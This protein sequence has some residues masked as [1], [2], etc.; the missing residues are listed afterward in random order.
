MSLLEVRDLAVH[1]H[2]RNGVVRAVEGVTFGLERGATLGVVGESGSGKSVTCLALMGLLACPPGR[3]ES[4]Q[5]LFEGEDLLRLSPREMRRIRGSRLG[6]VFQDPMEALNPYMRIGSQ[7]IE[8]L[9]LH[10]SLGKRDALDRAEQA[11]KEVGIADAGDRLRCYPHELSGGMRQRILIA[12]ALLT[13]PALLIADEPTTALDVTIQAQILDVIHRLQEAR[14]TAVLLVTHDLGIVAGFCEHVV[15]MYAGRIMEAA[16]VH[17]LFHHGL[18]PY[19]KALRRSLPTRERRSAELYTIPGRPPRNTERP[20][21]C[22]F[23]PRCEQR[24]PCCSEPVSLV[25]MTEQH[26]TACTRVVRGEIDP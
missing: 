21:G 18:H 2:T 1:F 4:G 16:P 22:P 12:M 3:I 17:E 11:L 26:A 5:I 19:T 6:M 9:R 15:V 14:G 10:G 23:A 7:M 25:Q 8:G 20:E 13:E 24:A